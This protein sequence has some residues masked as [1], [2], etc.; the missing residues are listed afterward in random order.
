MLRGDG[1]DKRKSLELLDVGRKRGWRRK[2]ALPANIDRGA[3]L[4]IIASDRKKRTISAIVA[5]PQ[6][7]DALFPR[8]FRT[9]Q[10]QRHPWRHLRALFRRQQIPS[11][12]EMDFSWNFCLISNVLIFLW[13]QSLFWC[14][15]PG[16]IQ[17]VRSL[18]EMKLLKLWRVRETCGLSPST[19]HPPQ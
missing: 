14:F 11:C 18:D 1:A 4:Q 7:V 19:E 17:G 10:N 8:C 5:F 6:P 12:I 9:G 3:S 13:D 15:T 2:R 16:K